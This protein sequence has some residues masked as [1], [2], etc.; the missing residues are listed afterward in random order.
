MT[1]V[2]LQTVSQELAGQRID[3]Y[4]LRELKGVPRTRI[5][6]LLRRGEV[7]VNGGR[8]K[9]THR[10]AA[11][12]QV[13]IPPVR[14]AERDD[15]APSEAL[16]ERLEQT[17]LYED[18][19]LIILNKPSGAAVHG[20]SGIAHGVIE[21][22]RTRRPNAAFLDL[23]HRID[24]DT[25]GCLVVAK[26]RSTLRA[27]H[28]AFREGQ[29]EKQYLALVHG[30]PLAGTQTV[31]APLGSVAGKGGERMMRVDP[32]GQ[33]A[34][35]DFTRINQFA[36]TSLLR[37]DLFTGRMHQIRVHAAH[38]GHPVAMDRRYGDAVKDQALKAAGLRRLFLHAERIAFD[39]PHSGHI[40]ITAPLSPS[41]TALLDQ[42]NP[43]PQAQ[44][45]Q[46]HAR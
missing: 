40:E 30:H 45:E 19:R 24:R 2:T 27:L 22:L 15:V 42:L 13:R 34:R 12:D 1:G 43:T 35:T 44:P 39:I 4:L 11:G 9:P 25:S 36:D 38:L 10:L 3:N 14:R 18:D 16:T 20:G 28:E 31:N 32:N 7:R 26:R 23:A 29:V 33:S 41:L 21:V 37:A 8:I 5:Y 46:A 6:R 17:I